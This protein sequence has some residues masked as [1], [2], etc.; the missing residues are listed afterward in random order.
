MKSSEGL[1]RLLDELSIPSASDCSLKLQ[2][3]LILLEKWNVR[4][5]LTSSTEWDFLKPLFAE[6]LWASG[7]YPSGSVRHLDI[8]SGAGFPCIPIRIMAPQMK[9]EMVESRA[10][11]AYFLE[12]AVSEL[13][14]EGS[15]VHQE[16]MGAFLQNSDKTWDCFSWKAMKIGEE[17]FKLLFKHSLAESR[18]WMFH[19]KEYPVKNEDM[20]KK[21][22]EMERQESFPEKKEWRLSIF[23]IKRVH[24]SESPLV[25]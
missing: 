24:K 17:E 14:L 23:R 8:G 7:Y 19:A 1:K 3:F 21:M 16:R 20:I 6:G 12:T 4:I 22:M 10:K 13:G 11:R 5:N 18:F 15:E 9:L 25:S 2:S